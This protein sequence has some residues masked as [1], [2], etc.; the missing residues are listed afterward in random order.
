MIIITNVPL[1]V[2]QTNGT[3]YQRVCGRARGCQ[4][5][6]TL[7]FYGSH[8]Y[9]YHRNID[10]DYVSGLSITYIY[11]PHQHIWTFASG[12]GE[13]HINEFNCPCSAK[14]GYKPIPS[15]GNN[16][17]CKSGPW[18]PSKMLQIIILM[19][20]CGTE[21]DVWIAATQPW[22]YRQLNQI[23]Q[24]DIEAQMC[25]H[26]EFQHKSTLIDQLELYID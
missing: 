1:P 15:V 2:F 19:T 21:Q 23:T 9:Y 5:G 18:Y 8:P 26:G 25:A 22:F 12:R 24:D 17:Y 14:R 11:S 13:K 6:N 20:R 7:A 10:E 4:K 16:Y 3:N